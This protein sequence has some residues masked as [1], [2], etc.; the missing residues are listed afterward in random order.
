MVNV[1]QIIKCVENTTGKQCAEAAYA[2]RFFAFKKTK[3]DGIKA[4]GTTGGGEAHLWFVG[5]VGGAAV[6]FGVC[7]WFAVCTHRPFA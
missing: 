3:M 4:E 7:F 1:K 5:F 6:V 2:D